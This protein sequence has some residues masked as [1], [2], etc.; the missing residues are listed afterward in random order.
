MDKR[1]EE[2][3]ERLAKKRAVPAKAQDDFAMGGLM[4]ALV[5]K[6]TDQ[7]HFI[8]ELL[9]NADDA[10]ATVARF[11]LKKDSLIFAHNGTRRFSVTD[12]AKEAEDHK[13]GSLG[14]INAITTIGMSSKKDLDNISESTIGKFGIG[15]KSVF[16]YTAT[17]RI[18]DPN[19]F[20]KIENFFALERLNEGH[21][22]RREGE[23]L[24]DFPFD[25]KITPKAHK[26]AYYDD[27]RKKL[28]DL[29]YP[30]LFLSNLKD[31]SF[32]VDGVDGLYGKA[33]E[34]T[35][36]FGDVTAEF[37]RLIQND[38]AD[39]NEFNDET[40]WLFSRKEGEGHK[41]SVGFFV[42][43]DGKLKS[44]NCKAFCFFLTKESTGLNFIIHAPFLLTNSREGIQAGEQHN[45]DMISLLSKLAADS[46]VFLKEIGE[47]KGVRLIDDDIIKLIPYDES[48]FS[49]VGSINTISFKPFYTEIKEAFK[50]EAI[51]PSSDGYAARKDAYWA[52]IPPIAEL[53]SNE[54]LA[55]LTENEAAKWVFISLDRRDKPEA[56]RKYIYEIINGGCLGLTHILNGWSV[57]NERYNG[58]TS[59]FIEAQPIEWLHRFYKWISEI[60]NRIE[61]IKTKPIFLNQ[62]SKAAAAFDAKGDPLLFL[63]TDD[64]ER[65][66]HTV[67]EILLQNK[68]TKSFI[69]DQLG[70]REPDLRD[71]IYNKI[72][73]QYIDGA[74]IDI[75]AL[76]THFKKIFKYY[77]E[78]PQVEK[79]SFI[80]RV[81]EYSFVLYTT[82]AD[83][84]VFRGIAG[85]LYL[86]TEDLL[87][88]FQVKP[89]TKFVCFEKYFSLV[90]KEKEDELYAFLIELG[91]K[92]MPH[93]IPYGLNWEEA[94]KIKPHWDHCEHNGKWTGR[95]IDGCKE[96]IEQTVK[97]RNAELSFFLWSQ[98]IKLLETGNLSAS[99]NVQYDYFF[100]RQYSETY[101]GIS[102]EAERL[103]TTPWL[104]NSDG[105]FVSAKELTSKTLSPQYAYGDELIRLLEIGE[106]YIKSLIK[107][108]KLSED[109]LRRAIIAY[110][111][112]K[113]EIENPSKTPVGNIH[114]PT[115]AENRTASGNTSYDNDTDTDT[116]SNA[117]TDFAGIDK[118][119]GL[120]QSEK[121]VLKDVAKRMIAAPQEPPQTTEEV[122]EDADEDDYIKPTVDI[123]KKS[124]KLREQLEQ[125]IWEK[126][127]FEE[128]KQKVQNS[129]KY[130]YA[131]F[132][133]VL[134]L[135][136]M[137]SGKKSAGSREISIS[138]LKVE[139]EEHKTGE[140]YLILKHPSRYIPQFMEDLYN[141]P[142]ELYFANQSEAV[143]VEIEVMSV[144]SYTLKVKL[145]PKVNIDALD[146]RQV[147]EAR[148][149]AKNPV[150]LVKELI[151]AFDKFGYDDGYDMKS[152]LCKNIE[153]IFGPP[154]TGKTTY[155]AKN[156][157]IPLMKE[158]KDLRVLVLA[159]TNKAA[160][161]LTHRLIESMGEDKSY[162]NWL[163]RFGTLSD[164]SIE[165][166]FR[167][168]TDIK[169]CP[170][171]VI[172]TTIARFA[173][174]YFITDDAKWHYLKE[175][176]W[177]YIVIDEA[178]MIS[179]PSIIYPL[180]K[181]T[182]EK[183]YIAGDPFQIEPITAVDE[184]KDENIYKMVGLKSFTNPATAPHDFPVTLLTTQYRSI[185]EIGAVFSQLTYGGVLQHSRSSDSRRT[186]PIGDVLNLQP[187]TIIKFPVKKYESIYSPKRLKTNSNYQAYSA[188]FAV[189]F[190]KY[191][192]GLI[193]KAEGYEDFKIGLITPY[194]AQ[195]D[196]IDKLIGKVIPKKSEASKKAA[197]E[198]GTIHSFQGDECNIIIALFN[199]PPTIS[200]SKNIFLNKRNIVNVSISRA[201]DY[202]ILLMPDDDTPNVENLRLIKK[203]ETLCKESPSCS[204]EITSDIEEE[205]FRSKT[206]LEDNSFSTSHHLVNVYG[207]QEMLYEIRG[208][209]DAVDVQIRVS[210]SDGIAPTTIAPT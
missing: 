74:K 184:L 86:P 83:E 16:K 205:L 162:D 157:I 10:K 41:Y 115:H 23:T 174:D 35:L 93:L 76:L 79:T 19:I 199:P 171:N 131:W 98:L 12:P 191:L 64:D 63:P 158:P 26:N 38:K 91:A 73:S 143:R 172:V 28:F 67:N 54:Q 194:R 36:E 155:L 8:Y 123:N 32:E 117:D 114:Y 188:L 173:Y 21:C 196:L 181:M 209:E 112:S 92:D 203:V 156:I 68:E 60:P 128:L 180:Y 202:L 4:R 187:L 22:E 89:E 195:A 30:L 44:N 84:T 13:I 142:L 150:F 200:N 116:D 104:V 88:W 201:R 101:H 178:S 148:I 135:E 24:F 53:F 107:R 121:R 170:R 50:R 20:F 163:V 190:A 207:R 161:V 182:P 105:D 189:E 52:D 77:Q 168:K 27:I 56:Q 18:Y 99:F 185:P 139:R 108:Y 206:Y 80:N 153:F 127:R 103:R 140:T 90:G 118:I 78:C 132:K 176:N 39:P 37:I 42:G 159:P 55:V 31:I 110:V 29:N 25:G 208:S 197:V 210:E 149:T 94:H 175:L 145:K 57:G 126:R 97:E 192:Y 61:L 15:F 5:E 144:K 59:E 9:Q 45:I 72:L 130:S 125:K 6:Y 160:D 11:V 7:A 111:T 186:L 169:D 65:G 17:P 100:Y 96:L 154:G 113:E 33:V 51:I 102:K 58:I 193:E 82:A 198:V 138:F 119:A 46:F 85:E 14:D 43:K 204:E 1:E 49:E 120:G 62:D 40:L 66:C 164:D 3:F 48:E 87:K 146:M 165:G 166:V 106:D 179:L 151:K 137:D 147:I 124:D 81:K 136:A 141:I 133:T 69:K 95:Y 71:E 75:N 167:H 177:D 134:E 34:E 129:P 70:I 109:D 152:E 2:Y 183:F 47:A 122:S